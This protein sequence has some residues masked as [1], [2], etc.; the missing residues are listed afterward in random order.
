[1][2][3]EPLLDLDVH[4]DLLVVDSLERFAG[5]RCIACL[6]YVVSGSVH[7]LFRG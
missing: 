6:G 1:M 4:S 3:D 7:D 2:K 5:R